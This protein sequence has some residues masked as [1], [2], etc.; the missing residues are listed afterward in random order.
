MADAPLAMRLR[1]DGSDGAFS[2]AS[3]L[4]GAPRSQLWADAPRARAKARRGVTM[5]GTQAQAWGEP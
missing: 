3:A 2:G 1:T 4:A 5:L